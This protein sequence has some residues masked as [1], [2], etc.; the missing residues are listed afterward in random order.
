MVSS[1]S[2]PKPAMRKER[3]TGVPV[4]NW[5]ERGTDGPSSVTCKVSLSIIRSFAVATKTQEVRS[6]RLAGSRIPQLLQGDGNLDQRGLLLTYFAAVGHAELIG[7]HG[8]IEH[9]LALVV[10]IGGH[11]P[12]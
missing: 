7:A 12:D 3:A 2:L 1:S 4:A 10:L 5:V 11:V 6:R 8:N 9:D